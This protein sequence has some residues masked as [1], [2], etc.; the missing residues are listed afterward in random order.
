[1]NFPNYSFTQVSATDTTPSS[2]FYLASASNPLQ[3]AISDP[4][5][6]GPLDGGG[7]LPMALGD[8]PLGAPYIPK[9]AGPLS[10]ASGLPASIGSRPIPQ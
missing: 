3:T 5:G 9:G 1:M 8:G 6:K 7:G 10:D 4:F 2:A